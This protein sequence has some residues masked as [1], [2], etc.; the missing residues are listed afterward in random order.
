[1]SWRVLGGCILSD[2]LLRLVLL[3]SSGRGTVRGG[4]IRSCH[5]IVGPETCF[6]HNS[7]R[8]PCFILVAS[9]HQDIDK[10]GKPALTH[11]LPIN[12]HT[13]YVSMLGIVPL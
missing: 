13:S 10:K 11:E 6:H 2:G 5:P 3:R 1:M 12:V 9:T 4:Q 8:R 7:G